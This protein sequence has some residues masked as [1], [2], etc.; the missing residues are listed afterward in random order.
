MCAQQLRVDCRMCDPQARPLTSFVDRT[1][2]LPW[3]NFLS[4]EFLAKFQKEVP[5]FS[6]ILEFP[7]STVYDRSKEA[8]VSKTSSTRST[9]S[10]ELRLVKDTDTGPRHD[11]D[12]SESRGP[13][14]SAELL[15]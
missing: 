6:E 9:I 8:P 14:A 10:I 3:R 12:T 1:I 4:P 13:S 2:D 5:L 15:V 7:E 11:A